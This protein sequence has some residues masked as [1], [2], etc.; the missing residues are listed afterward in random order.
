ATFEGGVA[1]LPS[2]EFGSSVR[3]FN[4]VL[5]RDSSCVL[6]YWGLALSAWGNPFAAGIKPNAQLERGRA[7]VERGRALKTGTER[8]RAFL[9][10]AARLYDNYQS[11]HQRQR[12][13]AYRDAMAELATRFPRDDEASIF[14]A[15]ALAFSADPNDKTYESQLKAGAILKRLQA[16]L[17][18]HPGI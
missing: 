2:F 8:E 9:A 12:V 18:D 17:P 16:R 4:E 10:A 14:Y 5:A 6:A 11:T 15:L 7:A 3:A 1:Q 13:V